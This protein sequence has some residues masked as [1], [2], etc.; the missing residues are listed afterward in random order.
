[1][2]LSTRGR[3][4]VRAMLDLTLAARETPVNLREI[5]SRQEISADYLEQL[6]RKLRKAGLVR[7]IR[8]PRGGFVLARRACE[9]T[10][11]DIVAAL[12]QDVAPV[13]CVNEEVGR[14]P[15][16]QICHRVSGCATHLFWG[17]LARCVRSFLENKTADDA[18]RICDTAVSGKPVMFYI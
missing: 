6:L 13:R 4:G 15:P 3:Y 9:I 18:T 8:G 7:S 12:E 5:A 17:G 14:E 1:M 2:R 16:E 11:W 10:V